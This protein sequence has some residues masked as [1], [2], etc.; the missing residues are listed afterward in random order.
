MEQLEYENNQLKIELKELQ[1]KYDLL[2]AQ[3]RK[4]ANTTRNTDFVD[5]GVRTTDSYK[6]WK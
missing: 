4:K 1:E 3:L 5:N 6:Y 2:C